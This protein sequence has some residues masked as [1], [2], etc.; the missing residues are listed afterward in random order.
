MDTLSYG[1][2]R[3]FSWLGGCSV[4]NYSQGPPLDVLEF[5]FQRDLDLGLKVDQTSFSFL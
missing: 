4:Q 2:V 3:A 5:A 1:A